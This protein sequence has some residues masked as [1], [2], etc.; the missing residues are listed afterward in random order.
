MASV[1]PR[2]GRAIDFDRRKAIRPAIAA[3]NRPPKMI[4]MFEVATAEVWISER[5]ARSEDSSAV[6]WS[7]KASIW[8]LS[9]F[10]GRPLR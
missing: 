9:S 1:M 4:V 8:S 5:T 7:S 3:E 10:A 6:I 2:T